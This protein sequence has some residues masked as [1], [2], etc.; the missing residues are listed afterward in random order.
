MTLI[1]FFSLQ[2]NLYSDSRYV[3][4]VLDMNAFE[5]FQ[6]H[7]ECSVRSFQLS[8]HSGENLDRDSL[9]TSY[10]SSMRAMLRLNPDY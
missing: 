1:L 9:Q 4:I 6:T 10:R 5:A 8:D 7:T 2:M 3:C